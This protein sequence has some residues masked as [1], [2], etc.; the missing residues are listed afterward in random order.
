MSLPTSSMLNWSTKK[1]AAIGRRAMLWRCLSFLGLCSPLASAALA[2][3]GGYRRLDSPVVLPLEDVA[4]AWHPY[5]FSAF[6]SAQPM[7][8]GPSGNI[9]L[10]GVVLRLP[11]RSGTELKAFCLHCPHEL[12]F[13]NFTEDAELG[14]VAPAVESDHPLFVCPCHFS[15]FDPLADGARVSGPADRGLYRFR[16]R[17][18]RSGV[19]IVEVEE[20]ALAI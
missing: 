2:R 17:V 20:T 15:V 1:Q 18:R 3:Q 13:V 10:K 14:L 8:G 19:E 6:F 12:C 4:E 9:L 11:R 7:A 16:L 5:P